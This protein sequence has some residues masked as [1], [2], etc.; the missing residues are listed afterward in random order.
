MSQTSNSHNETGKKSTVK[1]H[2][3]LGHVWFTYYNVWTILPLLQHAIDFLDTGGIMH[4]ICHPYRK[5]LMLKIAT[6]WIKRRN[7]RMEQN[8]I[9]LRMATPKIA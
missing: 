8:V 3:V 1:W 4:V 7:V 9:M 6:C 5:N 2:M